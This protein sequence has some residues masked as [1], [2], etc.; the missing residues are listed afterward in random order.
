MKYFAILMCLFAI[1]TAGCTDAKVSKWT[2]IGSPGHIKCYS[3][4]LLIYDGVSTG[5]I[6]TE[7]GSDGWFFKDSK[8][9]KLVRV[10]SAC[11][12]EN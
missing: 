8:T 1:A 5:K 4:T 6:S 10:S 2:S 9:G 7:K 11:V 12:I 3:G